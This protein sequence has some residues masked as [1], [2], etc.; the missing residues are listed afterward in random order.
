MFFRFF[1]LC[2]LVAAAS[3]TTPLPKFCEVV[4]TNKPSMCT[5]TDKAN[6]F[7]FVCTVPFAKDIVSPDINVI[8]TW[9]FQPCKTPDAEVGYKGEVTISGTKHTLKEEILKA[10]GKEKKTAIPGASKNGL[11]MYLVSTLKGNAAAMEVTLGLDSCADVP[12]VGLKCGS[13]IPD[14]FFQAIKGGATNPFVYVFH[15]KKTYNFKSNCPAPPAAASASGRGAMPNMLAAALAA[16][17]SMVGA[18]WLY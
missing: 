10:D 1:V 16:V 2:A 7:V 13:A 14:T 8:G 6:G 4:G 5:C 9:T 17:A 3:A 12:F 18:R 11:G 15:P